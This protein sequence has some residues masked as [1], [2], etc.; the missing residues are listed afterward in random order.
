MT[1]WSGHQVIDPFEMEARFSNL[2][3]MSCLDSVF[4]TLSEESERKIER[5]REIMKDLPKRE[6][7]FVDLYFFRGKRQTVIADIFGVS[8]PTVHY[9]LRRAT[10]RI[11]FL[12]GLPDITHER[13]RKLLLPLVIDPLDADI[14]VLMSRTTCQTEVAKRIGRSQGFVR[15]R[16]L[17]TMKRLKELCLLAD[18]IRVHCDEAQPEVF[19]EVPE[20]LTTKILRSKFALVIDDPKTMDIMIG[21]TLNKGNT[22]SMA[23]ELG[24]SEKD[25]ELRFRF[26]V[27][28]IYHMSSNVEPLVELFDMIAAAPNIM[29]KMR[30]GPD[31]QVM[32]I[33]A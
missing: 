12:L 10:Q 15:H 23:D 7:D 9:R 13:M 2:Q 30:S 25:V 24:V 26:H 27:G 16:Y 5:V 20:S 33:V 18:I 19:D 11:Q 6:A 4:D 14:M 1:T 28:S 3:S 22:A 8:Q 29:N 21:V 31:D 32:Y 17:R